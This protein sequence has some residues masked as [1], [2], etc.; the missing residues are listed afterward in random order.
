MNTPAPQSPPPGLPEH[1]LD[2][3][4]DTGNQALGDHYHE[5]TC[6]CS[7]WPGA[8]L[9]PTITPG[10]WDTDAFAIALPALIAAYEQA[11]AQLADAEQAAQDINAGLAD[12]FLRLGPPPAASTSHEAD[13]PDCHGIHRTAD[14]YADC[15][16]RPI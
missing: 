1:L 2:Q 16:G 11:Q 4:I 3:L 5:R 8:C 9:T 12:L 10:M 6:A 15:Y 14:G 13:H 7:A